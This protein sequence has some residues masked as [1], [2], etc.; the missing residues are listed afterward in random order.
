[1]VAGED[2]GRASR[3]VHRGG[4]RRFNAIRIPVEERMLRQKLEGYDDYIKRVPYRLV[5]GLW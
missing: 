3:P 2:H 1:M 4:P 5:P